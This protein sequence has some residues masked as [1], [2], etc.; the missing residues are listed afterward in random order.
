[1]GEKSEKDKKA[2]HE[3]IFFDESTRDQREKNG[4]KRRE[5]LEVAPGDRKSLKK[6]KVVRRGK[7]KA[8]RVE[9]LKHGKGNSKRDV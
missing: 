7:L 1:L 3:R 6:G 5:Y 4:A 8:R 2:G 9:R